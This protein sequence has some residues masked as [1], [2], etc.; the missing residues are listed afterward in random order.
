MSASKYILVCSE[1]FTLFYCKFC[2]CENY[3][4]YTATSFPILCHSSII[5]ANISTLGSLPV[6]QVSLVFVKSPGLTGSSISVSLCLS[7]LVPL[8]S[9]CTLVCQFSSLCG[10]ANE[11]LMSLSVFILLCQSCCPDWSLWVTAPNLPL[12]PV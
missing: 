10:S 3:N 9:G 6:P 2:I 4:I 7:L 1:Y 8:V 5:L 11:S 12:P